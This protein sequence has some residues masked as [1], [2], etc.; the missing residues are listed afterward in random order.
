MLRFNAAVFSLLVIFLS[1]GCGPV[2]L[3]AN[4]YTDA[5]KLLT[6]STAKKKVSSFRAAATMTHSQKRKVRG[7]V[8][9]FSR[10]PGDLRIDIMSPFGTTLS[11][12][13][14]DKLSFKLVDFR[15]RIL[16]TGKTSACNVAKFTGIN[17]PPDELASILIGNPAIISGERSV[18]WNKKGFYEI[19]VK[20]DTDKGTTGMIQKIYVGPE[21]YL[22]VYASL[23]F[24]KHKKIMDIKYSDYKKNGEEYIPYKISISMP[25][26]NTVITL[27]YEHDGV[28]LNIDLQNDAFNISAP[29]SFYNEMLHCN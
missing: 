6:N 18:R 11:V 27:K 13:A 15:N 1:T 8:F 26:E 2:P 21:S 7:Q 28:D 14:A 3:P 19:T 4:P 5:V 20:S 9:I 17:L 24:K 22:P 25:G 16:Y 23:I 12:L 10:F 29:S